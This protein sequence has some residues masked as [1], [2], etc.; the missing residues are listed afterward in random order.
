MV[1]QRHAGD[2][3]WRRPSPLARNQLPQA[4]P[5]SEMDLHQKAV[6]TKAILA[7]VAMLSPTLASPLDLPIGKPPLEI[8]SNSET[9]SNAAPLAET[10]ATTK[11]LEPTESTKPR[12]S[13]SKRLGRKISRVLQGR[14]SGSNLDAITTSTASS[15]Q[16]RVPPTHPTAA[17]TDLPPL[18]SSS[19]SDL[20]ELVFDSQMASVIESEL[21]KTEP[22]AFRDE[23]DPVE[24]Q[25]QSVF[26]AASNGEFPDGETGNIVLDDMLKVMRQTGPISSRLASSRGFDDLESPLE[27]KIQSKSQSDQ[28]EK[29]TS[30]RA[31]AAEQLLKA[32][33]LLEQQA[34]QLPSAVSLVD[35]MRVTARE[36]LTDRLMTQ[37]SKKG[38]L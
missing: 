33:R 34:D 9:V 30:A 37:G 20:K 7:W 21:R 17:Q 1:Q 18:P 12:I 19:T 8:Q 10:P 4:I 36:L 6:T 27:V 24:S 23:Q 29:T 28:A 14:Q 16:L 25:I 3:T 32:A 31:R 26:E 15:S 5:A 2:P 11:T 13:P 22:K 35:E 38:G